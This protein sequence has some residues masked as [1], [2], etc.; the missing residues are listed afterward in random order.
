MRERL[1][2]T[3][4]ARAPRAAVG[5]GLMAALLAGWGCRRGPAPV[6]QPTIDPAASG[7][8]AV[9]LYDTDGDGLIA[10]AELDAS[11][12]LRAALSRLDT[13]GD[14]G[15]SAD[16]VAER[17]RAWKA[18]RTGLASARFHVTLDGRPLSGGRLVLEPEP[19]LGSEIKPAEGTTNTFGD[20]SPSVAAEDLP[21]PSLPGGVHFG[22]YRVRI[23]KDA[24][25]RETLP[26]RYNTETVLGQEV[27]YDDPG[28][29]NNDIRF[30]LESRP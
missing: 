20:V 9:A 26:A 6:R 3:G 30:Q 18:M 10:G 22:L 5:L 29:A 23:T 11:P 16:E 19:F 21:D 4:M 28:M 17:V 7:R 1:E 24:A 2:A 12:P 15:V 13:D 25:G 8:A 14:G 27:S